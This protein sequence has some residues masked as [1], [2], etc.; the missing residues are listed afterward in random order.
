MLTKSNILLHLGDINWNFCD[1]SLN[2][3]IAP[4]SRVVFV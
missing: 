2:Y 4:P 1:V 3:T